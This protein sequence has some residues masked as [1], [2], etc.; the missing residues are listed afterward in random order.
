MRL[1]IFKYKFSCVGRKVY[2]AVR[3]AFFIDVSSEA[4]SPVAVM[5]ADISVKRHP[6]G[7]WSVVILSLQ[8]RI[9]LLIG[10][11]IGA[12]RCAPAL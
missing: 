6:T 8:N 9:P 7:D 12:G 2:A 1:N 4:G 5:H 10:Q 11:L 3:A